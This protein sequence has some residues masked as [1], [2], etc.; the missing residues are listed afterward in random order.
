[1]RQ[2]TRGMSRNMNEKRGGQML[3]MRY[4]DAALKTFRSLYSFPLRTGGRLLQLGIDRLTLT[5]P[6]Q[7]SALTWVVP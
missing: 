3:F 7:R 1:M 4:T 2:L 5:L 6:F